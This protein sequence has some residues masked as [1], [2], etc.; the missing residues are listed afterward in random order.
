MI[1]S[2][3]AGND[4]LIGNG[5]RTFWKRCRRRFDYRRQQ[6]HIDGGADSDSLQGDGGWRHLR[7]RGDEMLND[8]LVNGGANTDRIVNMGD[9]QSPAS[10]GH[11]R[12]S[13]GRAVTSRSWG[14]RRE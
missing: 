3:A 10:T 6:R 4:T 8:T 13:T 12:S 11:W 1:G 5:A 9:A 7:V 2:S 14:R